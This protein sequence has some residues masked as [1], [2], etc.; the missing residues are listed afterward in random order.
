MPF[1]TGHIKDA[2]CVCYEN[3]YY[4][5]EKAKNFLKGAKLTD[6]SL[7][8]I[9]CDRFDFIHDLILYLHQNNFSKDIETYV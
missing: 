8:I 2:D 1:H 3:K 5:A 9:I 7:M 6:H 4:H